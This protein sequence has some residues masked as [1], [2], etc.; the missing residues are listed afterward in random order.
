MGDLLSN[1]RSEIQRLLGAQA[2]NRKDDKLYDMQDTTEN[3]LS[4]NIAHL[5]NSVMKR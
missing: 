3:K 5:P 1:F 4:L 2:E